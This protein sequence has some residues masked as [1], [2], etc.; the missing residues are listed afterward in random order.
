MKKR[1]VRLRGETYRR[2]LQEY[3]EHIQVLGYSPN[4]RSIKYS[5][6]LEF[7]EWLEKE[8]VEE[9]K[10]VTPALIKTHYGYLKNRPHRKQAGVLNL[11]TVNHHIRS[12]RVFFTLLQERGSLSVN[13]M[14][15]LKFSYPKEAAKAR[16][17]LSMEEV[18]ELYQSAETLQERAVLSLA[19]GCGLRSMELVAVNT[20]DLRLKENYLIVQKGKGNKKRY[21]P[22]SRQVREDLRAYIEQERIIYIKR[23]EEQALLLNSK[24]ER[25]RK[26]TCRKLLKQL[27]ERAGN[28]E[29]IKKE[30]STHHLRHSIATHLLE[31][32]VPI[33]QVRDF[34]GH[35]QLETTEIYTRVNQRQLKALMN[36]E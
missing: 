26:Y 2:L 21:V 33:E 4:G 10:D 29:I 36:H 24:G 17:I 30:I 19:Y 31:Q 5:N 12:L 7:L 18:R 13:P 22:M 1:I 28:E 35:S 11:K 9:I 20:E 34:L 16:T 3:Q 15:V 27:I 14:S 32:G 25:M 8:G 23:E 6:V